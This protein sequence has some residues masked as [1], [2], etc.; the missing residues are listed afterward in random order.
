[1]N[2][3]DKLLHFTA[4]D[5][6][7]QALLDSGDYGR[8]PGVMRVERVWAMPHKFTFRVKPISLLLSAEMAGQWAD[9]FAGETS[10]AQLTNDADESRPAMS[11]EDGLD[12]LR[13]FEA[14]SL[15][16]VL[17]DPPY[18]TEQALRKYKPVQGGTAGR[19]EYWA[20]CKDEIAR[21]V[22]PGGKAICFGWDSTGVGKGRGFDMAR[23]LLVCH[24]ACHN[25]TIVTVEIKRRRQASLLSAEELARAQR[26]RPDD[27]ED[28][29]SMTK[30]Q[31]DWDDARTKEIM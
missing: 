28:A 15:D 19:A 16:G 10:P 2:L 29:P 8:I 20:K 27:V 11:H 5:W 18:S 3:H 17:F 26:Q 6:Q 9:P 30:Q 22:R 21:I 23:V 24:G 25:D 4:E 13:A 31:R 14:D 1:M 12:F 7:E